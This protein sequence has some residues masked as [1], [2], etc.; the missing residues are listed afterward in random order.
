MF[1]IGQSHNPLER[2][3][4]HMGLSW[5]SEQK[6]NLGAC[7]QENMPTSQAWQVELYTLAELAPYVERDYGLALP[8]YDLS[9]AEASMIRLHKPCFN[10]TH[11]PNPQPLPAKY[12]HVRP[13]ASSGQYL[14]V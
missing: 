7:I 9:I 5:R 13:N 8:R 11:N 3:Q 14:S 10:F 1:Y 2:L 4:E 6:S 12:T